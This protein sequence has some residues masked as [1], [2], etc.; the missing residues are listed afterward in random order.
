MPKAKPAPVA[1]AEERA[2]REWARLRQTI[3]RAIGE[4]ERPL[5]RDLVLAMCAGAATGKL[6][7]PGD[8][9]GPDAAA[10][11]AWRAAMEVERAVSR[12]E[13]ALK[14]DPYRLA[15]TNEL[16]W[17]FGVGNVIRACLALTG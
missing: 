2:R 5:A 7:L 10:P 9:G 12:V 15:R 11:S 13:A 3:D 6:A 17:Q 16:L 1:T 8:A 14:H 4:A